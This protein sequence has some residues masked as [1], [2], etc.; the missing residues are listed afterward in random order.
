MD[1]SEYA[2]ADQNNIDGDNGF[3]TFVQSRAKNLLPPVI[4]QIILVKK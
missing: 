4:I 1:V 2:A 3:M